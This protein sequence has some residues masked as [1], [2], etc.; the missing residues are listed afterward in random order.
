MISSNVSSDRWVPDAIFTFADGWNQA[1]ALAK[2]CGAQFGTC[3]LHAFPDG[4]TLLTVQPSTPLT[5]RVVALYR[6]LYEPNAK[7]T[8]LMLAANA[9]RSLGAAKII[10]IAP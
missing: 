3:E 2:M 8:D 4:E 6:S 10:L 1:Q 5:G 9:I 7:L